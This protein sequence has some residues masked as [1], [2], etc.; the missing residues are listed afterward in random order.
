[1]EHSTT[2]SVKR[3]RLADQVIEQIR[4][5]VADET[6]RVGDRL[7][8]EGELSEMFGVGRSTI[9]E[10]MRVLSHRGL[11]E[12]RHGEGTYVTSHTIRES[13]EERLQRAVLAD[14]YEARLYLELALAELAAQR[15][16]SK[17]VAAMRKCLKQR[18]TAATAGDVPAYFDADFAFHLAVAK[19][20]KSPALYDVYESFVQTVRAPLIHAVTP[21]YIRTERDSL[22]AQ[23][24]DA[25]AAGSAREVRRLVRSHLRGSLKEI[26]RQQ[27]I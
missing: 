9:R 5:L 24:C 18:K 11:V 2:R 6:Y 15:R 7:P 17:D 23:L 12:V 14:I 20:A 27:V 19:A 26:A 25:I 1:V 3:S 13:M 4:K 10:A 21:E 8:A 16:D 22:H